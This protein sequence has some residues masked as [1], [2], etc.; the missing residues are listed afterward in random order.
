M[1]NQSLAKVVSVSRSDAILIIDVLNDLEFPGGGNVFPWARKLVPLLQMVCSRARRA[2]LPIIF[3]ND[4]FGLWRGDWQ[5]VYRHC[6]RRGARGA[7]VTRQM[8]PLKNDYVLLKPRHSAFFATPLVQLLEHLRIKRLIL[9]G[10]STNLCVLIT[11][12]DAVMHKYPIVVLSDCCAAESD[13]DHNSVLT[14]LKRY[15]GATIC[16]STE[17][18]IRRIARK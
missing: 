13:F 11:A 15:L 12:H 6:A 18:R 9:A 14:Q 10:I 16:R 4:N 8:K 7:A 5:D 3:V 2:G 17:L 1:M